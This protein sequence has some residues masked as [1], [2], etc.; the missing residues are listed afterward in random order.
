MTAGGEN[1]ETEA[2]Q[3]RTLSDVRTTDQMNLSLENNGE[4]RWLCAQRGT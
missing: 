4:K 2:V 3:Y 1:D